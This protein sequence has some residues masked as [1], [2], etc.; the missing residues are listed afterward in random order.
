MIDEKLR[1]TFWYTNRSVCFSFVTKI[2]LHPLPI[3]NENIVNFLIIQYVIVIITILSC[4]SFH[5]ENL[6]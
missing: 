6:Y 1:P 2:S 5:N 3:C 4:V